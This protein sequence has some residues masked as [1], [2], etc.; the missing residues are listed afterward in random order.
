MYKYVRVPAVHKPFHFISFHSRA[1]SGK[2]QA[3]KGLEFFKHSMGAFYVAMLSA[4]KVFVG[5]R[6]IRAA[7]RELQCV[8]SFTNRIF[9]PL[10]LLFTLPGDKTS[11]TI[12]KGRGMVSIGC[13][14][15]LREPVDPPGHFSGG[16]HMDRESDTL[17]VG[18]R[19]HSTTWPTSLA[20]R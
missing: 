16:C 18:R 8:N 10:K 20:R 6:C 2:N 1:I 3:E 11:P 13:N 14:Y 12:V 5:W 15:S 4:R 9:E 7:A 17:T 19:D